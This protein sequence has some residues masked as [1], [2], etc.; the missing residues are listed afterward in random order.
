MCVF[1]VR[2]GVRGIFFLFVKYIRVGGLEG[3]GGGGRGEGGVRRGKG[4]GGGSHQASVS[5]A[6]FC[7][8]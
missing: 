2:H 3:G 8:R 5:S 6:L 1:D 4:G 7:R